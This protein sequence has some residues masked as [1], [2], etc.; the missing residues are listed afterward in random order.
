MALFSV[1]TESLID[2]CYFDFRATCGQPWPPVWPTDIPRGSDVC[3]AVSVCQQHHHRAGGDTDGGREPRHWTTGKS[4][5]QVSTPYTKHI[6][7]TCTIRYLIF[8]YML[9]HL[10]NNVNLTYLSLSWVNF[11]NFK[12]I[13]SHKIANIFSVFHFFWHENDHYGNDEN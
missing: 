7:C 9:L 11:C 13:L 12:I 3:R 1:V 5:Y 6:T 4:D 8:F 10:K 2:K